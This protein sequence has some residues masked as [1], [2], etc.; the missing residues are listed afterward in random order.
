MD[1]VHGLAEL[2]E[3]VAELWTAI[4]PDAAWDSLQGP[5]ELELVGD[6]GCGGA[7]QLGAEREAAEAVDHDEVG[8]AA[9]VEEVNG[10]V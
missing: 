4:S 3:G 6:G 7:L 9:V 5:P 8:V 10:H 1:H 2:L